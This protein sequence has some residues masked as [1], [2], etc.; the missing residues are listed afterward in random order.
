MSEKITEHFRRYEFNSGDG[1]TYPARWVESRLV[2]LCSSL[3]ALRS[4]LVKRHN[5][6]RMKITSGYRS[7]A[8]NKVVG[9]VKYSQHVAGRAADIVC[10]N[11][12]GNR[13]NAHKVAALIRELISAGK[14]LEGGVGE[15]SSFT[16]Y[17][18]RGKR[19]RWSG[20]S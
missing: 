10:Y 7:E 12:K 11:A 15:Y 17:D 13:I 8:H 14:M 1:I 9:G 5:L 4:E 3:E 19:A 20:K 6:A 16:H 2:P 18:I